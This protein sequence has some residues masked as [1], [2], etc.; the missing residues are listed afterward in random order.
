MKG[1]PITHAVLYLSS[2][3]HLALG[4]FTLDLAVVP[5]SGTRD[6]DDDVYLQPL[7]IEEQYNNQGEFSSNS[8]NKF[9]AT[10]ATRAGGTLVIKEDIAEKWKIRIRTPSEHFL[11][12]ETM[13]DLDET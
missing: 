6:V 3:V 12:M 7:Q 1:K 5:F 11:K 9:C 2:L 4:E 13:L 10:E 8:E